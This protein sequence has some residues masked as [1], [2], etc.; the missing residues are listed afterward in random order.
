MGNHCTSSFTYQEIKGEILVQNFIH[1]LKFKTFE[2]LVYSRHHH[3]WPFFFVFEGDCIYA[4]V[5]S[6]TAM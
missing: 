6:R 4:Y 3:A 5:L 2:S 1:L